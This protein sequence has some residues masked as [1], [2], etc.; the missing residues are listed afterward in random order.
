[1]FLAQKSVVLVVWRIS[2]EAGPDNIVHFAR[3]ANQEEYR[4]EGD[5][6]NTLL[7]RKGRGKSRIPTRPNIRREGSNY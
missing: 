2:S 1:M 5:N 6:N 3:D 7:S 4:V